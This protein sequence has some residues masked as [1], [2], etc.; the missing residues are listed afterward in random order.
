MEKAGDQLFRQLRRQLLGRTGADVDIALGHL[1]L[2]PPKV[3]HALAA[4]HGE[5]DLF[6]P[7]LAAQETFRCPNQVGVVAAAKAAIRREQQQQDFFLLARGKQRMRL[8]G[9]TGG[10]V[11]EERRHL[12]GVRARREHRLLGAAQLGGR[13]HLHRLGDL[14]R[15]ADRA[16]PFSYGL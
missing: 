11:L 5:L 15:I 7:S 8:G 14:L 9:D 12:L 1:H 16:D 13:D 4:H 6:F 10:E 2:A 3:V